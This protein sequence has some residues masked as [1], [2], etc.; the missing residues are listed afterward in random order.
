MNLKIQMDV[1]RGGGAWLGRLRTTYQAVAL[2]VMV[3]GAALSAYQGVA[4]A[5]TY[6][7]VMETVQALRIEVGATAVRLQGRHLA[8]T[9]RVANRAPRPLTL[10]GLDL[11]F[12]LDG[13]FVA[14]GRVAAA[15]DRLEPGSAR[16]YEVVATVRDDQVALIR[17]RLGHGSWRAEGVAVL[18]VDGMRRPVRLGVSSHRAPASRPGSD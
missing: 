17:K 3:L 7:R 18:R 8:L 15:P 5:A 2:G 14:S 13:R 6:L 1:Q 9:L 12:S 16:A 4:T 11:G 10:V